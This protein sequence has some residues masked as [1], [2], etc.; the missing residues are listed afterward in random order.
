MA[1]AQRQQGQGE[2]IPIQSLSPQELV[3]VRDRVE[4]DFERMATSQQQL[5]RIITRYA[6]SGRSIEALAAS[7]EGAGC[8]AF[9]HAL[10]HHEYQSML[11][12]RCNTTTSMAVIL[13]LH[14]HIGCC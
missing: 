2:G 12:L 4:A 1:P 14:C 8:V 3:N 13:L 7:K 6:A 5:S 9:G 11:V 10:Q